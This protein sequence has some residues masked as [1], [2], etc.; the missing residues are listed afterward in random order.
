MS[1]AESQIL[2][3]TLIFLRLQKSGVRFLLSCPPVGVDRLSNE[4]RANLALIT[5]RLGFTEAG[6]MEL[7]D[8]RMI[9]IILWK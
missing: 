9:V 2:C 8:T 7:G 1:P 3:P 5:P 4:W 6:L